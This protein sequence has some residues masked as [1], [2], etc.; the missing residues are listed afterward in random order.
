MSD[1]NDLNEF[2]VKMQKAVNNLKSEFETIRAGRANPKMLDKIFVEYY[3]SNT[4]LNQ[5]ANISVPEAR[6][7]LIQPWETSLLK[8][9]EKAIQ[10]SD[11][12]INPNNDGK[13]LRLILPPLSEEQ[14]K[15][16]TKDTNKKSEEARVSI[17]NIRR[18]AMD[19]YKK[20]NKKHELTDDELKDLENKIQ[21]LTDKYIFEVDKLL[22]NKN[23]EIMTV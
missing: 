11:L 20:A 4:P 17:R 2:E 7:I 9:I 22:S 16:L 19:F 18:D 13:V 1:I 12:G 15:K 14:R 23:K 5:V 21:K 6:T 3:G 8:A 10:T